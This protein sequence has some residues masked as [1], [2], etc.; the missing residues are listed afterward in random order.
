MQ[1]GGAGGGGGGAPPPAGARAVAQAGLEFAEVDVAAEEAFACVEQP[2]EDAGADQAEDG[3]A[4]AE[5]DPCGGE[6]EAEQGGELSGGHV[7]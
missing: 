4:E 2:G 5:A 7:S 1:R 6:E 3:F